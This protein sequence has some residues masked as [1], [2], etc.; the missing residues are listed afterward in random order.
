MTIENVET[1]DDIPDEDAGILI[2]EFLKI[3]DPET[4]EVFFEGRV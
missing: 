2:E 3:Y 4:G 1:K